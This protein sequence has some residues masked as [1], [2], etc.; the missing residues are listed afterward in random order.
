MDMAERPKK[1]L[2]IFSLVLLFLVLSPWSLT[3]DPLFAAAPNV[4]QHDF[5]HRQ[6]V[7]KF[8]QNSLMNRRPFQF[9]TPV[10]EGEKL[11][12]GVQR[13][14]FY[15]V[16]TRLGKKLWTFKTQGPIYAA[17]RLQG[18][19]VYFADAKGDVYCLNKDTGD[20]VW[21][22]KVDAEIVSAPLLYNNVLYI[23][24]LTKELSAFDAEKGTLLWQVRKPGKEGNFT[25]MGAADP[26][27][28]SGNI[29]IGYADGTLVAHDPANGQILWSRQLGDPSQEFHD[30]DATVL[31]VDKLAY[32]SSADGKFYALDPKT[33][34]IA[35]QAPMG[36]VN[37]AA[38]NGNNLYVTAGGV[39]YCF[40]A[41]D[42]QVLWEQN[43]ETTEL[44][45]PAVYEKWLA[46]VATKGKIYFLDREKGDILYTYFVKGGSYGSPIIVGDQLFLLSNASR[47][48]SF[49]F[50]GI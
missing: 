33:G 29:L 36:G 12:V 4:A 45:S 32:V 9:A 24:S 26:V 2:K 11:Y 31:L 38:L 49:Q 25:V 35:W 21:T 37:T 16:D 7:V 47:L 44:S 10:V 5:V 15:A 20:V 43:L 28:A 18:S 39:V 46:V 13:A 8:K 50:K 40:L 1:F 30:V 14:L 17:A 6:W 22:S 42:G 27:F 23:V 34:Q 48:Y 41:Q 3:P 19:H